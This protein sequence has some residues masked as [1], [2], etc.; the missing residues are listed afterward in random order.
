MSV[1]ANRSHA[2]GEKRTG[3][4]ARR[5]KVLWVREPYLSLI[6]SGRKTIEVRVGYENIRRLQPG[7]RLKLNDRHLA[8]IQRVGRHANFE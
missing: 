8:I 3:K 2:D 4:H 5:P 7:D 1:Q 6:L